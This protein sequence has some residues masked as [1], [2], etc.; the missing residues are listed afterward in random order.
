MS[1]WVNWEI[2]YSLENHSRGSVKDKRSGLIC[3]V[4]SAKDNVYKYFSNFNYSW[5]YDI[6]SGKIRRDV[7]PELVVNNMRK[8]F[9]D[10]PL[11]KYLNYNCCNE[12]NDY[13]IVVNEYDFLNNP[14]KYIEDAMT[15]AK[16]INNYQTHTR[17]SN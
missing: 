11:Q 10:N 13:C 6:Y 16:D 14:N 8:T 1:E 17:L 9:P 4:Q 5:A 15:R 3:V 7:L 2:Q 12:E